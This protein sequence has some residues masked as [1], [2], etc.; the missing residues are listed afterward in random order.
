MPKVG[1]EF[2]FTAR[3]RP[4]SHASDHAATGIGVTNT[5]NIKL[6]L[7]QRHM[8]LLCCCTAMWGHMKE[9]G[10]APLF[11]KFSS[12]GRWVVSDYIPW[13]VIWVDPAADLPI[14]G[15]RKISALIWGSFI[16]PSFKHSVLI[17]VPTVQR[18]IAWDT[19]NVVLNHED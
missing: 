14:V 4:Q 13:T 6:I 12:R 3:E 5:T 16:I 18:H 15:K 19:D 11:L 7:Y 8:L 1:F 9:W 17:I 2:P 10:T